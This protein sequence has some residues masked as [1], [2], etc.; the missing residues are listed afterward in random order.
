MIKAY[1]DDITNIII[2]VISLI[3][4]ETENKL[5]RLL[6]SF[7]YANESSISNC[8]EENVRSIQKLEGG[9]VN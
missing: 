6:K 2:L 4:Y 5:Y 7:N 8:K 3:H 1:A 9:V